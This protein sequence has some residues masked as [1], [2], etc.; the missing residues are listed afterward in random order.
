M[1]ALSECTEG[2]RDAAAAARGA[3]R[4]PRIDCPQERPEN[5]RRQ[6]REGWRESEEPTGLRRGVDVVDADPG[7]RRPDE[8]ALLRCERR[9]RDPFAEP[10]R[11]LCVYIEGGKETRKH[12]S[13]RRRG[14]REPCKRAL[15]RNPTPAGA[16]AAREVGQRGRQT[17]KRAPR[18]V[19]TVRGTSSDRIRSRSEKTAPGP[20]GGS[21]SRSPTKTNRVPGRQAETRAKQVARSSIEASSTMQTVQASS[22]PGLRERKDEKVE[23]ER[24]GRSKHGSAR[25]VNK[26]GTGPDA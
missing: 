24:D 8:P 18:T 6:S 2:F 3:A 15:K 5:S 9:G 19:R 1:N 12:R 22:L 10:E 11:L 16:R 4:R 17:T 14:S 13:R 20:M 25:R 7:E 26:E 23:P 21:W